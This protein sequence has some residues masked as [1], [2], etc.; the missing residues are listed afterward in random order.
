MNKLKPFLCIIVVLLFSVLGA[1][2]TALAGVILPVDVTKPG[3]PPITTSPISLSLFQDGQDVTD[4]WTPSWRP[5]TGGRPVFITVNVNGAATIPTS[6]Q[7][8]PPPPPD[9]IVFNG[10]DNPFLKVVPPN[11]VVP[12]TSAYPGNC[13]NYGSRSDLSADATLDPAGIIITTVTGPRTGFR[14]TP[15]DCGAMA[16]VRVT[17]S[18]SVQTFIVPRDS[19]VNGIPDALEATLCPAS[20]P[21]PTGREDN[22]A[23]PVAGSPV[24]DGLAAFDEYRCCIVSGE[25]QPADPRR[26]DFF[27]HVANPQCLPPP[28]SGVDLAT[29]FLSSTQSLLGGGPKVFPT[30]KTALI[31]NLANVLSTAQAHL[32]GHR[33][34]LTNYKTDEWVDNFLSFSETTGF[35]YDSATDGA[36][37]DR[38]INRNAIYPILDVTTGRRVQKGLRIVECLDASNLGTL[39]FASIGRLN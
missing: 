39:G 4:V 20:S 11:T 25:F 29:Y 21:C 28:P 19:N 13:T 37:S 16:V 31:A 36:V 30:D 2:A 24:G 26:R 33:P 1:R 3:L 35:V 34:G 22:D 27:V 18:N 7:L 38:Q 9:K 8:V 6:I 32:L 17:V 14:L 15:L 12:T 10:T 5:S 23:G